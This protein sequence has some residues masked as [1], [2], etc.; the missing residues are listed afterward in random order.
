M[1][2]HGF[3]LSVLLAAVVASGLSVKAQT[4]R[5]PSKGHRAFSVRE[6][7]EGLVYRFFFSE[8]IGS[9]RAADERRESGKDDTELRTLFKRRLRLNDSE[10]EVL[11][12]A[13]QTCVSAREVNHREM[14]GL[15]AQ[16]KIAQ[17]KA[18]L[19]ARLQAL[20]QG[21]EAAVVN[22]IEQL[23]QR[24]GAERFAALDCLSGHSI[25]RQKPGT[26]PMLTSVILTAT[27]QIRTPTGSPIP[28]ARAPLPPR[29]STISRRQSDSRAVQ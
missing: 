1:R 11:I 14:Q 3:H 28:M 7:P 21:D 10:H 17:D 13:A 9:Q 15:V 22:G 5:P 12:S 16:L 19:Q 18:P 23:R 20:R 27:L 4:A 25:I 2:H 8:L 24:L 26:T 6:A 29:P